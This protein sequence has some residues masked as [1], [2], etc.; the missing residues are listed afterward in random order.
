MQYLLIMQFEGNKTKQFAKYFEAWKRIEI[1]RLGF[2]WYSSLTL[3]SEPNGNVT[4]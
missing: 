1:F 2:S 3:T 4:N